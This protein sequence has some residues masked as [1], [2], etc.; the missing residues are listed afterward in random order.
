MEKYAKAKNVF[1]HYIV[2]LFVCEF[3]TKYNKINSYSELC[4]VQYRI[5]KVKI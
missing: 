1:I 3:V 4:S 5:E 2:M